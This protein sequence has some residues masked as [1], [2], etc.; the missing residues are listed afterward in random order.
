MADSHFA[1]ARVLL[2]GAGGFIGG[3]L[4]AALVD[5][6]ANVALVSRRSLAEP[7]PGVTHH[8]LAVGTPEFR[9]FLSAAPA[10]DY[11][12]HL[13]ASTL[14]TSSVATP[15]ADFRG[16]LVPVL[17]L[18]EQ[19]RER[20]G[21][22]RL[23][24]TSSASVYGHASRLPISESD[25]TVPVS[26]YGVSKL[27]AERYVAVYAELYG[28]SAASVRP[29]SVYGPCQTKQVVYR[30][31]EQL[32]GGPSRLEVMG[33]GGQL[34]D[35]VY[36]ADVVRAFLTVATHGRTDGF[37]Y[38]VATGVGTSVADLARRIADVQGV[39]VPVIG[40]GLTRRGDQENLVGNSEALRA[41]GWVPEW[42]LSD[43]LRETAGWFNVTS[44]RSAVAAAP[45]R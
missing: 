15:E 39:R 34:R 29:F 6:G 25:S 4:A 11:I 14:A 35:L 13:A 41:I 44:G 37:A 16:N 12:F 24:Y 7:D 20:G 1:D 22:T 19:L 28:L 27:A 17:D 45:V 21:A 42:S 36:V 30:L 5:L 38:N 8:Q 2:T 3:H 9:T 26:P 33:D 23:I 32:R 31:L 10:F 43:G 40:D 18:L